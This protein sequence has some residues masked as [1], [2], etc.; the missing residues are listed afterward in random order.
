MDIE[1]LRYRW[2]V[3]RI[4]LAS[5]ARAF[6]DSVPGRALAAILSAFAL[7]AIVVGLGS[8]QNGLLWDHLAPIDFNEWGTVVLASIAGAIAGAYGFY[9]GATGRI[10]DPY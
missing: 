3:K 10:S 4:D 6:W 8:L 1:D 2:M 9:L 7:F 5:G